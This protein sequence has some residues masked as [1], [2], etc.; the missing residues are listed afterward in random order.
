MQKRRFHGTLLDQAI[1][2]TSSKDQAHMEAVFDLANQ[3]LAELKKLDPRLTD[4][5]R[6]MLLAI[7][8]LSDQLTM[9]IERD[10]GAQNL[11]E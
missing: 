9:Q 1:V 7:N 11:D 4:Q 2:V 8:A 5:Q 10:K 6:L 3:Q